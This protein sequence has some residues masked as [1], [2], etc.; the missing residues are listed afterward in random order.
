VA[1]LRELVEFLDDYLDVRAL[2]DYP[3]AWNGLQ[4]DCRSPIETVCVATDAC[5]ATIDEAAREGAQ[6]LVVHHGLFWGEALPVTGRSYR[7]LKALLDADI[8]LYS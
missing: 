5:Q 4:V 7:R 2:P 6:L 1:D 3:G 8:A